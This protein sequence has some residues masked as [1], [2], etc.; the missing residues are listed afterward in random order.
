[1]LIFVAGASGSGKTACIPELRK[2]FPEAEIYDFDEIGVPPNPDK[3]W[4]QR[5]TEQWLGRYL[6][7]S[8]KRLMIICGQIVAGEILACPS[9]LKIIPINMIFLDVSDPER[10]CRLRMRGDND[11][12]Q[13]I[14]NWAAWLGMHHVDPSWQLNVIRDDC[15]N[16]MDF[17]RLAVLQGWENTANI[18]I[19]DTTLINVENTAQMISAWIN[20]LNL[21]G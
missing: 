7:G 20:A 1:M 17:G 4:R 15:W 16:E 14:L 12:N 10:I 19:L 2:L 6:S 18:S 11:I 13:H 21:S 9:G 8:S 5:A 3:A